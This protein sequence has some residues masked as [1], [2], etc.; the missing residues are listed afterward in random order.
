[1]KR[2]QG[3]KNLRRKIAIVFLFSIVCFLTPTVQA[4]DDVPKRT[5]FKERIERLEQ[6]ELQISQNHYEEISQ[7]WKQIAEQLINNIKNPEA[8][9]QFDDQ[10][11]E[12]WRFHIARD[13]QLLK[14]VSRLRAKTLQELRQ[15]GHFQ[16]SEKTLERMFLEIKLIPYKLKAYLYEKSYWFKDSLSRGIVG[17]FAL[18]WE[19]VLFLII[20][21]IPFLFFKITRKLD[22]VIDRQR[23]RSF[24]Y[25][26]RSQYH[27]R[28]I[29]LLSILSSYLVWVSTL[30]A[31][32]IV[33]FLLQASEF[34]E[35]T[36]ILPY[37]FYYVYYKIFRVSL[38]ILLQEFA[39]SFATESR[40]ELNKKIKKTSQF[41]GL[42]LLIV[43]SLKVAFRSILG[44]SI[45]FQ[46][47]E[48]FFGFIILVLLFLVASKWKNEIILYLKS[49]QLSFFQ[50]LAKLLETKLSIIFCF[51]LL[52]LILVHYCLDRLLQWSSQFELVKLIYARIL[53]IKF[54]TT[55]AAAGDNEGVGEE[56]RSVFKQVN[57]YYFNDNVFEAAF[58]SKIK[59]QLKDWMD[60]ETTE[61]TVAI[62]GAKG[63][64][65]TTYL[66]YYQEKLVK[67]GINC[68]DLKVPAKSFTEK[69]LESLL[70]PLDEIEE[71]EKVVV[72][73]DNA[74]NFFLSTIGGFEI[75]RKFLE[76]TEELRNVFFIVGFNDYSWLFLNS[77]LGKNQY[78]RL[79]CHLP[80]WSVEKIKEFILTMHAKTGYTL[81]Y[82]SI[83]RSSQK[84]QEGVTSSESRYFYL[85]WERSG[86]NPGTAIHYWFRSL[87]QIRDKHLKVSL[88]SE[89]LVSELTGLH[90][91]MHFVYASLFKHENLT[92]SEA[93]RATNL[94]R[95]VVKQAIYRG[96]EEGFLVSSDGRYRVSMNWIDDLRKFLKG[97]NLI[98]ESQ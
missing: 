74:Q 21:A 26:F 68:L 36:A 60:E 4:Q 45:I 23:K 14:R 6:L 84:V 18:F 61:Q 19:L 33:E 55:R 69:A 25:S 20:L 62:Y 10:S 90:Q 56:Y 35:F 57:Q 83:F 75:Y 70:A 29:P 81:E 96:L 71:T 12:D 73:M 80:R 85:L 92:I 37:A 78:F 13:F 27:R 44:E 39:E 97:K 76:K 34:S 7:L 1:M 38:E 3:A 17:M 9:Q 66:N 82:D 42:F 24:Y 47:I 48:P 79:E 28:L 54:E 11:I 98:Y 30:F 32:I 49:T 67:E 40:G 91:E 31:L 77:V 2:L 58:H 41:I 94:P 15:K 95:S 52:I 43:Y 87:K 50:K 86:G 16:W 72:F 53:R 93:A 51:P 65:I 64:G 63:V 5:Q 59:N 46:M 22:S 88:P 89:N 8:N